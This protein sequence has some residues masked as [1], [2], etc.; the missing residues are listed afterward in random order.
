M[1]DEHPPG[2]S[3]QVLFGLAMTVVELSTV[4]PTKE[5]PKSSKSTYFRNVPEIIIRIPMWVDEHF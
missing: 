3:M 5:L 1:V 2:A 4:E